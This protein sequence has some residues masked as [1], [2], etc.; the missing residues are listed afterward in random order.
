MV[1]HTTAPYY[2]RRPAELENLS[3]EEFSAHCAK[4]LEAL[5][6]SEGADTIAAMVAEPA[7]GT[8]GLVPPPKGYWEAITPILKQ[9]DIL[10]IADESSP[11]LVG[12]GRC[13]PVPST[14]WNLTS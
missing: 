12:L 13:S 2:Y 10:L 1:K 8:G 11:A 4:E 6:A 7:L 14:A 3:E 9:H 5:I